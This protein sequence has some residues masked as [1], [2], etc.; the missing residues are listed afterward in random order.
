MTEGAGTKF[1]GKAVELHEP[2]LH[3]NELDELDLHINELA[4]MLHDAQRR[5]QVLETALR[6]I[7]EQPSDDPGALQQFAATALEMASERGR[8]SD[9]ATNGAN[10]PV[11]G[12]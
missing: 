2:D 5:T 10:A 6:Q 7:A 12:R 8:Q 11:A 4:L 1:A 3:I 9:R